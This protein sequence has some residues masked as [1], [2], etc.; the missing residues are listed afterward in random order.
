MTDSPAI[1]TLRSRLAELK[2]A[3]LERRLTAIGPA[4]GP[5]VQVNGKRCLL[6]ASNDYLGLSGHPALALASRQAM[7]HGT[8]S[9]AS[10]L[11]SGTLD[12]HVSLERDI[13]R[14]KGTPAALFLPTGYMT[15]LALITGLTAPGDVV[16]SDELNHASI[17]D[18]CRLSRAQVR[19]YPHKD[20]RALAELLAKSGPG[21]KLIVSDGVFS[22][23][24]DVAP[25]PQLLALAKEHGAL[26][27]VDDA[28]GTGVWGSS[29]RGTAEHFS[30]E[31]APQLVMMG[32]FSKALGGMGGFVAG[33]QEIIDTLVHR[34]RPFL[35]STAPPPAQVAAAARSLRLV[36]EEPWRREKVHQLSLRLRQGMIAAGHT[37]LSDTG[38]IA[39]LLVGGAKPAVALARA[40]WQRGVFVPAVRPPTVPEGTS[41]L[42]FTLTAAH[43]EEDVDLAL[44]ALQ[45]A[46]QEVM[47]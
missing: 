6:M 4:N 39:P 8:G 45:D 44:A 23:D 46:W 1:A 22:M 12:G 30:L 21:L 18:A 25:L 34:A 28:H 37:P 27:A 42:R 11:I 19:V 7:V 35:Y 13:A 31:H 47:A 40:M 5:W 3:G 14:F 36:D 16:L 20:H 41:R 32:T 24:G 38:P 9:G 33:A 17:V 43:T 15:N 29:G 10:R 2:D 26:L